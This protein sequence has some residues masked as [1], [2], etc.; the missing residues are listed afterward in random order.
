M[1]DGSQDDSLAQSG[2]II[3]RLRYSCHVFNGPNRP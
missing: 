1:S 2:L 3:A